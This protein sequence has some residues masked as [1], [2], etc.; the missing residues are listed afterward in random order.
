M[1][2]FSADIPRRLQQEEYLLDV[3]VTVQPLALLSERSWSREVCVKRGSLAFFL[4]CSMTRTRATEENIGLERV[5]A[6]V[7]FAKKLTKRKEW[8]LGDF[9]RG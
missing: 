9:G 2:H 8:W 5:F 7:G 3:Y 6:F 1:N 4:T